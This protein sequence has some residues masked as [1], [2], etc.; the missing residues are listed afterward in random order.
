MARA[1]SSGM[2]PSRA[3]RGHDEGPVD[4]RVAVPVIDRLCEIGSVETLLF[5]GDGQGS[6]DQFHL[7]PANARWSRSSRVSS[8]PTEGSSCFPWCLSSRFGAAIHLTSRVPASDFGVPTMNSPFTRTTA[9]QTLPKPF[10]TVGSL[11]CSSVI[12]PN[13]RRVAGARDVRRSGADW[14]RIGCTAEIRTAPVV[15]FRRTGAVSV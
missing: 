7:D 15:R 4:E 8:R 6:V 1:G 3:R 10:L 2:V 12:S 5:A 14:L 11:R 9:R 13:R